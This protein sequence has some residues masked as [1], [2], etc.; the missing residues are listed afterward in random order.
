MYSSRNRLI[1]QNE[2]EMNEYNNKNNSNIN[3]KI[4]DVSNELENNDQNHEVLVTFNCNNNNLNNQNIKENEND[5]SN[6]QNISSNKEIKNRPSTAMFSISSKISLKNH[7]ER[8][9]SIINFIK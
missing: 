2:A 6:L 7:I 8:I 4:N 9:K 5:L 1:V 3:D